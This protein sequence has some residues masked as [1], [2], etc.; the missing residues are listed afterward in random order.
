MAVESFSGADINALPDECIA[1]VLSLTSPKDACRLSLVAPSFH[2]AAQF[3]AVWDRFLPSD[4]REIL[5]TAFNSADLLKLS[6]KKDLYFHLC[7]HPIV[8][9]GGTKS[10]SLEKRS[11]KKCYM[12]APRSLH[13]TW[14]DDTRYWNWIS[15]PQS[16]FSEV[17]ELSH[18]WWLE[19]RGKI[20]AKLLSPGTN[21]AAYLVFS[22][23]SNA[24]GFD[25]VPIEASIAISEHEAKTRSVYLEPREHIVSARQVRQ[26][27]HRMPHVMRHNES[28]PREEN[29]EYQKQRSDHWMEVELG[30]IF[31]STNG[32]EGC[33][34]ISCLE[35]KEGKV[36]RGLVVQGIE[37]RPKEA[38]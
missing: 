25:S 23:K 31:I 21:Y 3:D 32:E 6:S 20:C 34:D 33:I 2:S 18:V 15:L 10:F 8:I 19:I 37:I 1:N 4:C 22:L 24:Y 9:D 30:D 17:P 11:G 35:V 36:K 16:R 12:L 5:S 26:F 14:G 28:T 27:H 29:A 7:D 13:I 38:I